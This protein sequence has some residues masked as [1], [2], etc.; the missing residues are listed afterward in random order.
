MRLILALIL[1]SPGLLSANH[2]AAAPDPGAVG[3][4]ALPTTGSP[5]A[6]PWFLHGLAQLHNFEYGDAADY[7]RE[8]QARDPAFALA[9]WGEAMT[10]NHPIWMQQDRDAA[11]SILRR[12]APTPEA[13]V[14][15]AGSPLERDLLGAVEVLYG[16]GDKT[17]RDVAYR[18]RMAALHRKYADSADVGAFY[19]LALLG[20]AHGGRDFAIYMQNFEKVIKIIVN[21]PPPLSISPS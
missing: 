19:A 18:D 15:R 20:T 6:Q 3:E 12:L 5:D 14:A 11:L 16:E 13:R 2:H 7:F 4:V 1:L 9:Y 21:Y 17:S 8:A 10:H